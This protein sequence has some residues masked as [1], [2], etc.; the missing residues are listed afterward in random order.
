GAALGQTVFVKN[1][2]SQVN[3]TFADLSRADLGRANLREVRF[4]DSLLYLTNL[5]RINIGSARR[6]LIAQFCAN[7]TSARDWQ[8]S[9]RKPKFLCGAK[10]LPGKYTLEEK[11]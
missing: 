6:D 7:L 11:K 10:E 4:K 1:D 5:Q 3:F 9:Y 2:L 8:Y